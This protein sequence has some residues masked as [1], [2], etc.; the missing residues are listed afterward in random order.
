[1]ARIVISLVSARW[2]N[3]IIFIAFFARNGGQSET[4]LKKRIRSIVRGAARKTVIKDFA[5]VN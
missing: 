5:R 4:R 1:M 2:K 3:F